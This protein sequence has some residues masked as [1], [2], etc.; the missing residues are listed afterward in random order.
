MRFRDALTAGEIR[1]AEKIDGQWQ[2]NAWVKQGILLGFRIGKLVES[3]DPK[4]LTFVD[5]GTY[6]ARRFAA[7]E[8]DSRDSRRL[9]GAQRGLCGDVGGVHA[10]DVHQRGRVC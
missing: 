1:A 8:A 9:V 2:T 10:A 3:G 5:K 4:V 7:R 6:P